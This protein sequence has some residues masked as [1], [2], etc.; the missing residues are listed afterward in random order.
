MDAAASPL[1]Q[2]RSFSRPHPFSPLSSSWLSRPARCVSHLGGRRH[3][4]EL[5]SAGVGDVGDGDG[6]GVRTEPVLLE[7]QSLDAGQ[8][9]TLQ[10]LPAAGQH[11]TQGPSRPISESSSAISSSHDFFS[12]P[13]DYVTYGVLS[14]KHTT[15]R[16]HR[17]PHQYNR[18]SVFS[19]EHCTS[20]P[21]APARRR[22][23]L[24]VE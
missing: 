5:G 19:V 23:V 21:P 22:L 14:R 8:V 9:T 1:R 17:Q 15:T 4:L 16:M 7:G 6:G 10:G 12:S 11:G 2:S 18:P 3:F 24:L 13:K 20:G